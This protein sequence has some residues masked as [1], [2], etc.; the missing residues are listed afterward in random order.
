MGYGRRAWLV[1]RME[2]ATD[3][4][5]AEQAQSVEGGWRV[6][7]GNARQGGAASVL[8]VARKKREMAQD[9]QQ[10]AVVAKTELLSKRAATGQRRS[11]GGGRRYGLVHASWRSGQHAG[12]L[13]HWPSAP[14]SALWRLVALL[15]Q[16]Q[17][18]GGRLAHRPL[19]CCKERLEAMLRH[20]RCK[21][22]S[23]GCGY[24]DERL[25]GSRSFASF[26]GATCV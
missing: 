3:S 11:G 26:L 10:R 18:I 16:A 12:P 7:P 9:Q 8:T 13:A 17:L 14:V 19:S 22:S 24:A 4:G 25:T 5:R 21:H 23:D 20:A 2:R 6:A 1:S 15:H